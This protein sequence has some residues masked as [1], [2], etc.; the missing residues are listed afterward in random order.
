MDACA[1]LKFAP[2]TLKI[3]F[4]HFGEKIRDADASNKFI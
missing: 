4:K 1:H 3:Y 2:K